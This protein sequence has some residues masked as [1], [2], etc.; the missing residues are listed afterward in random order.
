MLLIIRSSLLLAHPPPGYF[1]SIRSTASSCVRWQSNPDASF[2]GRSAQ[3]STTSSCA[4]GL[5]PPHN[6]FRIQYISVR[7]HVRLPPPSLTPPSL[8]T[9]SLQL[10]TSRPGWNTSTPDYGLPSCALNTSPNSCCQ[11]R[12]LLCRLRGAESSC[13]SECVCAE[14]VLRHRLKLSPTPPF[15]RPLLLRLPQRETRK[16]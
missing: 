14:G 6:N 13:L 9:S 1:L 12:P 5:G 7:L 8:V 11:H 4:A 15:T 3:T 10:Y 16:H 2:P